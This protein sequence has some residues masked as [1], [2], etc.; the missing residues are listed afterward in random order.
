LATPPDQ[1]AGLSPPLRAVVAKER[2]LDDHLM[3]MAQQDAADQEEEEKRQ[4]SNRRKEKKRAAKRLKMADQLADARKR[5]FAAQRTA[6]RRMGL[7]QTRSKRRTDFW[8]DAGAKAREV[9]AACVKDYESLVG[10]S[11][12]VLRSD[13]RDLDVQGHFGGTGLA[14]VVSIVKPKK[15]SGPSQSRFGL[16]FN[17]GDVELANLMVKTLV[18]GPI[19]AAQHVNAPA[20]AAAKDAKPKKVFCVGSVFGTADF[21]LLLPCEDV[22]TQSYLQFTAGTS[23]K[24]AMEEVKVED[25]AAAAAGSAAATTET[26]KSSTKRGSASG[27]G[28]DTKRN[29]V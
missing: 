17:N 7:V 9:A 21:A 5:V 23:Y 27:G 14:T 3:A 4:K 12:E 29:W 19:A 20:A 18:A 8:E 28:K 24:Q 15:K 1:V 6:G 22:L 13:C 11:V 2:A 26:Q 16:L 25:A 10:W